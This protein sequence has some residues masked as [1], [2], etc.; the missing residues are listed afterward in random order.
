VGNVMGDEDLPGLRRTVDNAD[1]LAFVREVY[2]WLYSVNPAFELSDVL[3]LVRS[4]PGP[5]RTTMG[6]ARNAALDGLDTGAMKHGRTLADLNAASLVELVTGS[7]Q[8]LVDTLTC[9]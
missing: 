7:A 4:E 1:D 9:P 2:S 5:S 8:S 3:S 6:A